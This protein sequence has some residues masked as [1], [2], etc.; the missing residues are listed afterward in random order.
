M[1][2]FVD[3][4]EKLTYDDILLYPGYTEIDSRSD[5]SL[6]C[7]L[8]NTL[9]LRYPVMS[10]AMDTVTGRDMAVALDAC[11]GIGIIHRFQSVS[12]RV[13]QSE[14][15]EKV[16]IAI[17]M[18][19]S[20]SDIK[21]LSSICSVLAF[22]VANGYS[23]AAIKRIDHIVNWKNPKCL[24]MVGNVV[25][26]EAVTA[27]AAIGADI[28][29]VG[30]GGGAACTT[31]MVTGFGYPNVSAIMECAEAAYKSYRDVKIVA[32]GGIRSSADI[33]KALAAGADCVML[34]SLLAGCDEAPGERDHEGKKIYRGMASESAQA[35]NGGLK[36]GTVAEGVMGYV[37]LSGPVSSQIEHLM[38]GLRSAM[39][40]ADARSIT[41][42]KNVKL[43]RV[44]SNCIQEN[45][46][47]I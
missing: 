47:R 1:T 46:A 24:L 20:A 36:N 4:G 7:N 38:G 26:P 19:E 10:A 31:R 18:G 15:V 21:T 5:V 27:M 44:T 37:P 22:D 14:G 23:K 32:D 29:K 12:E 39:T 9:N 45:R 35:W 13:A 43:V 40:Y 8:G 16:G 41:E 33:A 28:V 30:I 17:G 25:H 2:R 11:G 34:G 6:V 3:G 42:L